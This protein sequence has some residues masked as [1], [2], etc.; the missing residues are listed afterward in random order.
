MDMHKK[1][2]R[3]DRL[4]GLHRRID[5]RD[6]LNGMALTLAAGLSPL[7]ATA[8]SRRNE[9]WGGHLESVYRV[10]HA[11]RDGAYAAERLDARDSSE[12]FDVVIVGAGISGLA[13]ATVLSAQ[14]PRLKLLLLDNQATAGGAA[15]V[16]EFK[17]RGQTLIAAQGSI[18]FQN[19][20]PALAPPTAALEVLRSHFPDLDKYRVPHM[21]RGFGVLRPSEGSDQLTLY[22][23]LLDTPMPENVRAGYFGFLGE[24]GLFYT[25]EAWRQQLVDADRVTFKD[26]VTARGWDPAVYD[27]MIPELATFFGIPDTVSAAAVMRQYAGGPLVIY[28]APQGNSALSQDLLQA[29]EAAPV[30]P[31]LRLEA[32]VVRAEHDRSGVAVTYHKGGALHRVRAGAAI[33]AGGSFV[34]QYLVRDQP[35]EK[36]VAQ[37]RF[38]YAPIVWINVALNNAR[39]LDAVDPAFLTM[40]TGT[41]ATLL[42]NYDKRSLDGWGPNRDAERPVVIGLSVPFYNAGGPARVQ[43]ANGRMEMIELPFSAYEKWVRQDLQAIFGRSGFDAA[44]DIAAVS[45]C[46]W[47]HG[48]VFPDPGF[49]SDGAREQAAKPFGRITYANT[50]LDGFSHLPGAVGHGYRAAT[51]VLGFL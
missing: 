29:L 44:R 23:S 42:I 14:A 5:R 15:Q 26:Y 38:V 17:L 4:L 9:R 2:S 21:D 24:M 12:R 35:E 22:K 46:R 7:S 1:F 13:A 32:T 27:W 41:R 51:E 48:Y 30:K 16:D 34:T 31:R 49:L 25:N 8:S 37:R 3:E 50:D 10:G 47:G 40:L 11:L 19:P 20:A 18:T 33:M 36:A 45:V 43:A 28:S 6:F 39:A